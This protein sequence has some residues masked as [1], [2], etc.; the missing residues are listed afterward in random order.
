MQLEAVGL[1]IESPNGRLGM[2]AVFNDG[3]C[4]FVIHRASG[5]TSDI[6]QFGLITVT[7]LVVR[8]EYISLDLIISTSCTL[9][10]ALERRL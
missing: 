8:S 10:L 1:T 6:G 4:R 2:D 5:L 9:I 7:P 3:L